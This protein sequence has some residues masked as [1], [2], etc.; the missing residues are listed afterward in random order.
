MV[1]PRSQVTEEPHA[2]L[3]KEGYQGASDHHWA[4]SGQEMTRNCC[5]RERGR[6]TS[7]TEEKWGSKTEKGTWGLIIFSM[8]AQEAQQLKQLY[9]VE[10]GV[11]LPEIP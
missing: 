11:P 8:E 6:Q 2:G 10:G 9:Q 7:F 1:V 4:F 5:I 3:G